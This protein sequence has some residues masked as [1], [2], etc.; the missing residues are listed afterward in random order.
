MALFQIDF[1]SEVLQMC[2]NMQVI[3]P[4][5]M[6]RHGFTGQTEA[7]FPSL[8]LLH[9]MHGDHTS[10]TRRTAIERYVDGTPMA[11][12][13]PTAH[14]SFYTDMVHGGKYETYFR[15]ELPKIIHEFFPQISQRREDT[16]IGGLSMGGY[17]A[18][19][20]ALRSPE[21]YAKAV[22]LSA[23]LDLVMQ[24]EH[25]EMNDFWHNLFGSV[26]QLKGSVND[27]ISLAADV[28]KH[29]AQLPAF[30]LWCGTDDPLYPIS[31]SGEHTLLSLG[32]AVDSHSSAGGHTWDC[33]DREIERAIPWLLGTNA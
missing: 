16:F 25:I 11:V 5:N 21:R 20:L 33:W 1:Y 28:K 13:M 3:L 26:D 8:L 7:G 32:Y 23:P 6:S 17:G 30:Y 18:V 14:L 12:I 15:E 31:Q 27:L 22:A 4:Q 19:K 29:A 2:T 24:A 10:W 9:G